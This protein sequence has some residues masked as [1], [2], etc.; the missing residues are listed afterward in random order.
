MW[1]ALVAVDQP[2]VEVGLQVLDRLV[3]Q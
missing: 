1:S 3:D 2:D